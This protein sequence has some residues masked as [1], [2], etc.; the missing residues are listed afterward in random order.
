MGQAHCLCGHGHILAPLGLHL[1]V[2]P[3]GD[4][5]AHRTPGVWLSRL[6][7]ALSHPLPNPS[8]PCPVF[9]A[10]TSVSPVPLKLVPS[11]EVLG[12]L[13]YSSLTIP[14]EVRAT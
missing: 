10:M 1:L 3:G 6:A 12:G 5:T 11:G 4:W 13:E 9:I 14:S 2:C 7:L 8:Q